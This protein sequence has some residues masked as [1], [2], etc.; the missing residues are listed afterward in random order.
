M[1]H[2]AAAPPPSKKTPKRTTVPSKRQT[3]RPADPACNPAVDSAVNPYPGLAAFK[4]EAHQFFFGR[5]EDSERVVERLAE[6]R[7]ISVVG[8]SGSGKSSLVAAGVVPRLAALLG[9]L[10]Y[11]RC[12]PQASPF[13]QLAEVLCR[14][15][16]GADATADEE[17][18]NHLRR[19]LAEAG[20]S[21]SSQERLAAACVD[22]L[23]QRKRPM[24]LLFDQFEELFAQT[25]V[26]CAHRFRQFFGALLDMEGLYLV[27]TLRSEFTV[28]LMEWL[29]EDL[30]RASLVALQPVGD[31]EQ[32]AAIISGPAQACGVPV[33]TELVSTLLAA[34]SASTGALPLIALTL[35]RLFEQRDAEEGMT[36]EAYERMGGLASIVDTVAASIERL[37]D[38]EPALELACAQLFAELATVIDEV[39]TRRTVEIAPLRA[40]R[41]ISRL[42][43]ALRGQGFLSDPDD[44]HV[45]LAHETLL[46]HWPR[47]RQWCARY[48][49]SLSL[50]RQAKMAAREWWQLV[51]QEADSTAAGR[52][53]S[54][55]RLWS[56]E[57]QKPV[58]LAL[59]ELSH[60]APVLDPDDFCDP[61][62][63]AWRTLADS[64]DK[65]LHS[66]LR[67]E[68]LRLLD[69]LASDGT[70]HHRREEIGLRLNQMG[71][72]RRGVGLTAAG[73]PDI[74]WI[75]IATGGE[76]QLEG[77]A[78]EVFTVKPLRISRYPITW[79][80]YGA[81]LNA[82]DG[83][84]DR[85]WWR[86]LVQRKQPGDT[87]WGF[88]NHPAINIAWSDA[89]AFCRW[90]SEHSP[91]GGGMIIRLPTEWEWQWVAQGGVMKRKYPWGN[92]WNP[93][94]ANSHESGTG[95]T[96]AVGMY[97]LGS[98]EGETVADLAGNVWEW[99]LNEY[100]HPASRQ[101]GG[102]VSR[103]LR[104]GSWLDFPG[105]LRT[106]KREEFSPDDRDGDIGFRVVRAAPFE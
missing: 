17:T 10:G 1:T 69:E 48:R 62:I 100:D 43:D 28:R 92:D 8:R 7:L 89:V 106:A 60:R 81:F 4:P 95:R 77:K 37:I 49:D 91:A 85:R 25:P 46:I 24:L 12:E 71:D 27:L 74:V 78:T 76:V 68:P 99:C 29:G 97:P 61:G 14:E 88:Q 86:K 34:A 13:Q 40:D 94:R 101:I 47:L 32:L 18:V 41:Q 84:H 64:L 73:L 38:S 51:A 21:K 2:S 63:A 57:R 93:A 70:Q 66:F 75:D 67:P 39:P 72:P 44:Q 54:D 16:P 30:F 104:G 52:P 45:E 79:Q 53:G 31:E 55:P 82:E 22:L 5:D 33:Q 105:D 56:W 102:E 42:V 83:Y 20:E 6:T 23:R 90:L 36:L 80:Q 103:T 59:L 11:L 96:M 98:P 87:R 50:R 9:E 58:L 15:P 26:A 35:E 65:T 19:A 3:G